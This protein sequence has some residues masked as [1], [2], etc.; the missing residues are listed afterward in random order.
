[1]N[2]ARF[3]ILLAAMGVAMADASPEPAL[4]TLEQVVDL[5]LRHN[6]AWRIAALESR[7]SREAVTA[8]EAAFDTELFAQARM[9]RSDP[10]AYRLRSAVRSW[11]TGAS[12]APPSSRRPRRSARTAAPSRPGRASAWP[13]APR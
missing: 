1:M 3:T 12:S 8:E 5:T 6:F 9:A 11:L 4:L 7:I 13:R 10:D 2:P